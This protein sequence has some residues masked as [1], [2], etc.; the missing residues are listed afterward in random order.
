MVE[1]A[2]TQD[3][4][5]FVCPCHRNAKEQPGSPQIGFFALPLG[6]RERKEKTGNERA[7]E[8]RGAESRG[9]GMWAGS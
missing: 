3:D 2:F 7:T 6:S 8:R 5:R 4:K 1:P 9:D